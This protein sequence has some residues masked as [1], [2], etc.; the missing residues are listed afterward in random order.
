MTKGANRSTDK[1]QLPSG[2]RHARQPS[3]AGRRIMEEIYWYLY[4]LQPPS[5]R[6]GGVHSVSSPNIAIIKFH[7][8]F[9]H[10]HMVLGHENM[11]FGHTHILA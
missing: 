11:V 2:P 8:V 7:I 10:Q 4:R 1:D 3:A 5:P 6:G 9:G